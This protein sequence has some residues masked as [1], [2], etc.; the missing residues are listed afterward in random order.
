MSFDLPAPGPVSLKVYDVS[1]RLVQTL[2]N[3]EQLGDGVRHVVW[4]G[5]DD[6][7]RRAAPGVY[8]VRIETEDTLQSKRIVLVR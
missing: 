8:L 6:K 5:L 7:G 2:V 1:G 4:T 3:G